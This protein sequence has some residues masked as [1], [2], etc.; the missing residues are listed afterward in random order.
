MSV[1]C[2][3][4]RSTLL[5]LLLGLAATASTAH[6]GSDDVDGSRAT[7]AAMIERFTVDRGSLERT[8]SVPMSTVRHTRFERFYGDWLRA[9]SAVDFDAL[10]RP[11]QVDYLLLQDLLRFE[12]SELEHAAARDAELAS[13]L[14]FAARLVALLDARQT[15]Q[16]VDSAAVADVLAELTAEVERTRDAVADGELVAERTLAGRGARRVGELR[17]A[18]SDYNRFYDRYDPDYSWWARAPFDTL[19]DGL[20]RLASVIREKLS[21]TED[22]DAIL[23]DPIGRAALLDGLAHEWIPYTPEE[24]IEIAEQEFAWCEAERLRA[25]ADLGFGADWRAA[26]EHVKGLHVAPG[27]QPTLIRDL[28]HEAVDF[29]EEHELVTIPE[30]AKESWRMRMMTPERQKVNPYFTGGEVISVSF[31]TSGM[32]HEQ[33]LMSMRGNNI[34]FS[35]ATVHHELIPG[36]HLQMFMNQRYRTY[37]RVFGTPFWLEGWALYWEMLLWDQGFQRSAEDRTGMLFWRSHRCARIIFSLSFHLG[38]MTADEA[39]EFLIERV[40]HE[41]N[42]ATAEVRRSVAGNYSPLYQAA[43]MLGGLQFRALH[44]ELVESGRMTDREMHD[45]ILRQGSIPIELLRA[46]MT[47]QSLSREFRPSW[48]FYHH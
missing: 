15:M 12:S 32:T 4:Y 14:P 6:A 11:G 41:R 1:P 9:L 22:S 31:P 44:K 34:H 36:H 37:R 35:R 38:R 30:L 47:D 27:D 2:S 45:F 17:R 46:S 40:G 29:L 7:M 16:P 21:R 20:E 10:D 28:A 3:A 23:G 42:N 26:L 25:A 33:K 19:H 18:L 24:L 5:P 39:I 43:Y 8:L 48:R 13:L